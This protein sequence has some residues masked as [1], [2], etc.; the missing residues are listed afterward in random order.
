MT[1]QR[2]LGLDRTNLFFS[3]FVQFSFYIN[4]AIH[5]IS[6]VSI[7]TL[8]YACLLKFLLQHSYRYLFFT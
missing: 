3:K 4:Q 2:L 7:I 5:N 1:T 8:T 6:R